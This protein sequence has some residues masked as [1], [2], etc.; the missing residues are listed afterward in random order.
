M[1]F[2]RMPS[3]FARVVSLG[4]L[5]ALA[6]LAA[7]GG[8]DDDSAAYG[9]GTLVCEA[10]N[11]EPHRY[12]A[13][14]VFDG[15]APDVPIEGAPAAP[16]PFHFES[17]I[18]G[19]VED[20]DSISA[21]VFNT[22]GGAAQGNVSGIINDGKRFLRNETSGWQN[23][24]NADPGYSPVAY[25]PLKTCQALAVDF[26]PSGFEGQDEEVNGIASTR[27]E[28]SEFR[29]DFPDRM[30]DVGGGS[31]VSSLVNVF[32]GIVWVSDT[33]FISKLDLTGVGGYPDGTTLSARFTYD[34]LDW[35]ADI[36]IQDPE[37]GT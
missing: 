18:D 22:D 21:D 30:P 33:G 28:I 32:S 26:D 27:Y 23:V 7:C 29:S 16:P 19:E 15:V 11:A 10:M 14:A 24:D 9:G 36:D 20:A 37:I 3:L 5:G 4:L 12:A 13:T 35:G 2:V 34:L 25:Q 8:D 1:I 31:E 6:V 17:N